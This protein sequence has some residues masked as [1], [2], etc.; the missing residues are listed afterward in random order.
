MTRKATPLCHFEDADGHVVVPRQ[1]SL[2][3]QDSEF[4]GEIERG[5]GLM[6][7]PSRYSPCRVGLSTPIRRM[8][9]REAYRRQAVEIAFEVECVF[10]SDGEFVARPCQ[11]CGRKAPPGAVPFNEEDALEPAPF[12]PEETLA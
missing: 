7:H 5:G 3:R 11:D 12:D 2:Q 8:S 9:P 6:A 4:W 1:I 10:D